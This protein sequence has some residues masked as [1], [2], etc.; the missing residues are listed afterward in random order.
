MGASTQI[1]SPAGK[2]SS[3]A[4]T[5]G[6]P[7]MGQPNVQAPYRRT[8]GGWDQAQIGSPMSQ[9]AGKSGKG[10]SIQPFQPRPFQYTQPAQ[11]IVNPI[12]GMSSGFDGRGDFNPAPNPGVS[13]SQSMNSLANGPLGVAIGSIANAFGST[14]APAPVEDRTF[15]PSINVGGPD[16]GGYGLGLGG[17][18]DK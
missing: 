14:Q 8:I 11:P 5:S 2:G 15:A 9:G 10:S 7:R 3:N 18:Y 17:D 13:F 12:T 6:Q 16:A 1:S 4:S